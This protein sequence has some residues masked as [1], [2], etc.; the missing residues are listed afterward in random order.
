M[1]IRNRSLGDRLRM[2]AAAFEPLMVGVLDTLDRGVLIISKAGRVLYYNAV[3]ARL[4]HITPGQMIG[5]PLEE[6]DRRG[7]VRELLRL[8]TLPPE[9]AVADDRRMNTETLV[10]V[11]G[12]TAIC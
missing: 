8:G 7:A 3:Y 1:G 10:A 5:R 11:T 6:L 2:P 12:G 9:K 4:R